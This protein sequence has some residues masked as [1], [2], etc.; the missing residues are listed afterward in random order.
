MH[1]FIVTGSSSGIGAAVASRLRAQGRSVIGIAHDTAEIV[2][3][4][5]TAEGRAAAIGEALERSGGILGGLV[6]AAGLGPHC[7]P[8]Q[9]A[10]V[11][12]FGTLAC[13]DGW[14]D[15]LQRGRGAA[16]TVLASTGAVQVPNAEQLPLARAMLEGDEAR[17]R[18]EAT[19]AGN[20]MLAY[21]L[22]KY[23][24]TCSIRERSARWAAAGV[25]I[26]AVAPGPIETPMLQALLDDERIPEPQRR[27]VP[28]IGRYGRADEIAEL[29]S[30]LHSPAAGFIHGTI[31]FIDGGVDALT[32][33]R[34]F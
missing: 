8:A 33:P 25:R 11:N 34:H 28:P 22:S 14:F 17:A 6:C 10:S 31:I 23:A 13:V 12:V 20:G 18:A 30:Y 19:S 7:D 26:N 3:D 16:A 9:I 2:A 32:R 24:L 5:S 27:F 29:V 4:L 1:E 15:A 21:C